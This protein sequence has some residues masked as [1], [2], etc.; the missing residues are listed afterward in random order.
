MVLWLS[1]IIH[2]V[3]HQNTRTK[4]SK[5]YYSITKKV[6]R[7]KTTKE[8]DIRDETDLKHSYISS[9]FH[10]LFHGR[11]IVL[12]HKIAIDF[13][14]CYIMMRY[15]SNRFEINQTKDFRKLKRPMR[16]KKEIKISLDFLTFRAFYKQK[17]K[18]SKSIRNEQWKIKMI[19][20]R[21]NCCFC[22]DINRSCFFL[23]FFFDLKSRNEFIHRSFVERTAMSDHHARCILLQWI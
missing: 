7:L 16:L 11:C 10:V 13:W 19:N 21:I 22:Y 18:H 6:C 3:Y 14:Q 4:E 17:E 8:R 2:R 15:A 5:D 20:G 9:K 12:C 23:I 1:L